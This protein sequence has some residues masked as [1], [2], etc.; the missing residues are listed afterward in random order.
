MRIGPLVLA[1]AVGV[2]TIGFA[3]RDAQACGGC[4]PPPGEQNSVVT[5][6]R[7]LLS[8][9]K[10]QST[11]YDQI[12]Y[13]GNPKEFA[14]VLPIAGTVDVGLS[15]DSLFT[16]L[17]NLSAVSVQEPP[18]NCPPP[19]ACD[20]ESPAFSAGNGLPMSPSTDAGVNVLKKEVVGPYETVQ[21]ESTDPQALNAW[22]TKNGFNIPGDIQPIIAQYVAEKFNFLALRLKP[23]EG[24]SSMR[25]VRVT[26]QGSTA[27]L[28]LRMVA[29][30]A[31]ANVGITLWVISEG[32][33]EPQNFQSFVIKN[34]ELVWDWN[35]GTSN[36]K[37]LRA[38]RSAIAP[39]KMW[40]IESSN[41][42]FRG[43][44]ESVVRFGLF[45]ASTPGGDYLPI[46]DENG[47]IT[48]T[49]EAVRDE[50]LETVFSG[51]PQGQEHLTRMRSDLSR[52]ALST[53]LQ[54][55]A[56]QDQSAIPNTRVPTHELG[57]PLCPIYDGCRQ[58]GTLPR[59]QAA[60]HAATQ[61]S[62]D[63][64]GCQSSAPRMGS[65][66]GGFGAIGAFLALAIARSMRNRR[67]NAIER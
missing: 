20:E 6:H 41:Q 66:F 37:T 39:G 17:H 43:Q 44:I 40:E 53:D 22:L 10:T 50:D 19:P 27:V 46:E 49:A 65:R 45:G 42:V 8:V 60:K 67:R 12:Q 58:V 16:A 59:D 14:W 23:G 21:L 36:Y 25:P 48:K 18:R 47:G 57:Q 15:A 4:F 26:T 28:P 29:A 38:E 3:A 5:D 56:S 2:S 61:N 34:E 64:G 35:T 30:G 24:V 9:S 52:V 13:S 1:G 63:G 62:G 33:Y 54:I 7:M 51:I 11:L 31:G 55:V 32:R